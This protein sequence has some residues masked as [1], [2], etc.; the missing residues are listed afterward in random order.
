MW[1]KAEGVEPTYPVLTEQHSFE[2]WQRHQALSPSKKINQNAKIKIQ[3][4][5][6]KFKKKNF[7]NFDF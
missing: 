3:N 5:K 1:R 6:L 4:D 2:D 7:L